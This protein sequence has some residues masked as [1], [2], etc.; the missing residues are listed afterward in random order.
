MTEKM[1]GGEAVV[2]ALLRENVDTVFGIPGVHTLAIY[3]ALWDRQDKLRHI[4]TRHE[5]GAGFMADGYARASG[6]P[7]VNLVI[8]GPGVT[9]SATAMGQAFSDS[10][11]LLMISSQND[12]RY[13]DRDMG[14]LHQMKDQMAHTYGCTAWNARIT[15]VGAIP[16]AVFDAFNY[17]R[18][19]RPRPVHLEIPTDVLEME[20]EVEVG[21]PPKPLF[22]A[23]D[24]S[25]VS[26]AARIM[27]ES[28]RPLIW[29][30]GGAKDAPEEITRLV[31]LLG[32]AV[33]TTSAGKGVVSEA[34]PLSLGNCLRSDIFKEKIEYFD[35]ILVI[36][37][38]LGVAET[39]G[40]ELN[41][42][43]EMI[44]V[45]LEPR[46]SK[47]EYVPTLTVR[48]DAELFARALHEELEG[49]TF[50][51]RE[52]Y[53][54]FVAD[55]REDLHGEYSSALD[56]E[57]ARIMAGIRDALGPDDVLVADMTTLCYRASRIYPAYAP[58]TYLF[59]QGFG[60]LGWS[61]PAAYGAKLALPDRKVAAIAG[62]GG[63]LF[64][65]QEL[66][67]AVKYEIPVPVVIPNNDHYGIVAKTMERR[68]GRSMA[69]DIHNP[70]YVKYA[71]AFGARGV[72]LE[73]ASQLLETLNEAFETP[74]P[75]LIDLP[76]EF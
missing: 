76:V 9:N 10:S 12:S 54:D 17:L 43:S 57:M 31:E 40:G 56:L 74:G 50:S 53:R 35:A 13:M 59:P 2:A 48:S 14:A 22:V 73:D 6:I 62:D 26:A 70:D 36:G 4:V 19:E 1:T 39:A 21:D 7:G 29:L 27:A 55:L 24:P 33:I 5:G 44:W 67:T 63:F 58:R 69:T 37:S 65:A 72:R 61:V 47:Y 25:E 3:D 32:A 75:T 49:T 11:P 68:Y 71:E 18:T 20:S 46:E 60:T 51:D 28:K 30:G 38:E 34:H 15:E 66:A 52:S 8:T 64:A 42:P 41:L 23:P 16:E 45:D